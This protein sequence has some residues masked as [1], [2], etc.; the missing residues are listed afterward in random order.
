MTPFLREGPKIPVL[1]FCQ[2]WPTP[3][4]FLSSCPRP[5]HLCWTRWCSGVRKPVARRSSLFCLN[6]Q[7]P[8]APHLMTHRLIQIGMLWNALSHIVSCQDL[9]CVPLFTVIPTTVRVSNVPQHLLTRTAVE[10]QTVYLVCDGVCL[11]NWVMLTCKINSQYTASP[12]NEIIRH[13]FNTW[14]HILN[15]DF[16]I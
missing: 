11:T 2:R 10:L 16:H 12:H 6:W 7:Y 4:G 15:N 8:P 1:F 9:A 3:A 5:T 14:I 13:A